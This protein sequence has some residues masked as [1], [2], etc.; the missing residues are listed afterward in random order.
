MFVSEDCLTEFV[1]NMLIVHVILSHW[2]S[3]FHIQIH[4]FN[5]VYYSFNPTAIRFYIG[6]LV[7]IRG[8]QV[9]NQNHEGVEKVFF[10]WCCF[11]GYVCQHLALLKCA[12]YI[13][14]I[15]RGFLKFNCCKS[16]VI[17]LSCEIYT[18]LNAFQYENYSFLY[19]FA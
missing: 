16:L 9:N 3:L 12:Q 2:I 1:L 14:E 8:Y 10:Q 17:M 15:L 5:R 6:N 18:A 19:C 13:W 7:E 4:T 11:R